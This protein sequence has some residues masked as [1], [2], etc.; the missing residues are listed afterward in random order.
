MRKKKLKN[1]DFNY[2]F[3]IYWGFLKKYKGI[4]LIALGLV[5]LLETSYVVEKY[6]LKLIIDN[7]TD[8]VNGVVLLSDFR[9]ILLIVAAVFLFIILVRVIAKYLKMHITNR[10]EANMIIDLKRKFFDHI[11]HLS[12][13][14]HTSHKTG[15][16]ISRIMRGGRAIESLTDVIIWHA[17]PLIFQLIVVAGALMYFDV[18]SAIVAVVT[19]VVFIGYSIL[20]QD[21]Q[22]I[23]GKRMNEEEDREKAYIA[24][25]M[26]NI[27]SV[28]FFGKEG[29]IKNKFKWFATKTKNATIK[30]WDFFKLMDVGQ[31]VILGVGLF[32]LMYF[33]IVKFMNGLLTIGDLVFIFTVFSNLYGPMWSFVHGT[34][35]YYRAMVDFEDLF[36][37]GKVENDIKDHPGSKDLNIKHGTVEFKDVDFRYYHKRKIFDDFNLKIKK[38]EKVAFV[39]HSGSGKT[40]LVKL[41]YRLFDLERGQILID[42]QDIKDVKQESL[43]SGLS[44]V[45]QECVLFDDTIWN[46]IA[47]SN[48]KATKQQIWKAIRFAQLDTVIAGFPYKEKTVVGERG[49]K[50]SGGEKQRVSI[51]RALLAD[52]KILV[53]DEATSS[54]DSETEHE[55]QKDLLKLMQNRTSIMI[56]HRLSTIMHADKIV[57]LDKGRIVQVGTHKELIRKKGQYKK[58]W[59]LQKGGYLSKSF[60]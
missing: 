10:L 48:P 39:G 35:V 26:T 22:K 4:L 17:A 54:L 52:K 13:K 25:V 45:P 37:Y 34:R 27:D 18:L 49:V 30:F 15:S 24:D 50:L 6:L 47:F 3:K 41:L 42:G 16:L 46:N 11:V 33:P 57:V 53:L 8:F 32:L 29:P 36:E 14:F 31:T 7:G 2:N 60:K 19:V 12:H 55:I 1:I 20:I 23:Y 43:R 38:N 9:T 21:R 40:T 56:A 51:A 44:I 28:K 5:L 59:N 58:L